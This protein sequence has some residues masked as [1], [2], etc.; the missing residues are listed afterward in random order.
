ML[1]QYCLRNIFSFCEKGVQ[2]NLTC[3][4]WAA[5]QKIEKHT[6]R[7][8]FLKQFR[9]N[10]TFVFYFPFHKLLKRIRKHFSN[11][12]FIVF[13]SNRGGA[14]CVKCIKFPQI[15]QDFAKIW[16]IWILYWS[17][18]LIICANLRNPNLVRAMGNHSLLSKISVFC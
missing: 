10:R 9:L 1:R 3:H 18:E 7:D 14:K 11:I 17:V 13:A 5:P 15:C 2:K 12:D 16:A 4:C 8:F 6:N